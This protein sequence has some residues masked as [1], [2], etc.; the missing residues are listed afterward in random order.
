MPARSDP[1]RGWASPFAVAARL[2][3]ERA[4]T[5]PGGWGEV[6]PGAAGPADPQRTT[7]EEPTIWR[8]FG[9]LPSELCASTE[10]SSY[11]GVAVT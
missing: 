7:E 2:T 5:A 9:G 4:A 8:M 1:P 6:A 11:C 3:G 10:R